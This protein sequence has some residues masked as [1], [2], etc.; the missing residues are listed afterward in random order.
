MKAARALQRYGI[1]MTALTA[2][3]ACQLV[4]GYEQFTPARDA[5]AD[6]R[7]GAGAAGMDSGIDSG[8]SK[9]VCADLPELPGNRASNM[10]RVS[11]GSTCFWMDRT[12]VSRGEY[13]D[14]LEHPRPTAIHHPS[15]GNNRYEPA[16]V[17]ANG[18]ETCAVPQ[19]VKL[20]SELDHPIVCVD[21]C[22]AFGYCASL[23]KSLCKDTYAVPSTRVGSDW[24]AACSNARD[25]PYPFGNDYDSGICNDENHPTA[26]CGAELGCT[27]VPVSA[28][29]ECTND[30]GVFHLTG[31]VQEWTEACDGDACYVR[32]GSM[33]TGAAGLQCKYFEA[34]SRSARDATIGFRCCAY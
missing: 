19:G 3:G 26:G 28:L 21:W 20:S 27:T 24:Y 14:F 9:P 12:E 10:Q 4:G 23:G 29:A 1:G 6:A 2:V 25:A 15:C 31:N 33:Q 16:S 34:A 32:G 22:D 18:I 13:R 30:A 7:A 8:A 5:G 17:D 11:N